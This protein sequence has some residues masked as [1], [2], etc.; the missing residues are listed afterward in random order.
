MPRIRPPAETPV[1]TL[2]EAIRARASATTPE[3][4]RAADLACEVAEIR[5]HA[6]RR[7]R[8][9][10]AVSTTLTPTFETSGAE[11]R[12]ASEPASASTTRAPTTTSNAVTDPKSSCEHAIAVKS[13]GSKGADL[14]RRPVT[15]AGRTRSGGV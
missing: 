5:Y 3:E 8:E 2:A 12:A 4:R 15:A 1:K 10:A 7:A 9:S 14:S 13:R 6:E 11:P